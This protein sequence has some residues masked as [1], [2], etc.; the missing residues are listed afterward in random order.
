ME[1]W[2]WR[3]VEESL[4]EIEGPHYCREDRGSSS[5][6]A[7]G[8]R[9]PDTGG[10]SLL[11]SGK[12]YSQRSPSPHPQ[13]LLHSLEGTDEDTP[14]RR[15]ASGRRIHPSLLGVFNYGLRLR[16]SPFIDSLL[17]TIG[18]PLGE[19]G[20]FSWVTLT[21]FQVGYLSVGVAPNLNLFS[22]IFNVIHQGV[23]SYFYTGSGV[24]NML[25]TEKPGK[26]NPTRWHRYWF[27]VKDAFSDDVPHHFSMDYT[28][29]N[30][31]DFEETTIEFQKLVDG[32][33]RALPLIK[34]S[35]CK[36]ANNF[37]NMTL[38]NDPP[39][40][41]H[42]GASEAAYAMFL[43]W[44]EAEK[45]KEEFERQKSSFGESLRMMREE[46][47]LAL[48]EK[49]K[50]AQT[51]YFELLK[52]N[53]ATLVH[54]FCHDVSIDFPDTSSHFKMYVTD[55]GEDYVTSPMMRKLA[56]TSRKMMMKM[57]MVTP[58]RVMKIEL[59]MGLLASNFCVDTSP[60][61]L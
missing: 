13:P 19:L 32:F 60:F 43:Q 46:R 44:S 50:V 7:G 30:P 6:Q 37:P 5:K 4:Q 40:V 23:L 10:I 52:G 25:D 22:K 1:K 28:A 36:G 35:L 8:K 2:K 11:N 9:I 12:H 27:L 3:G 24:K 26:A 41:V 18:R 39:Q 48:V 17:S 15:D 49:E 56:W 55:L 38:C 57:L 29:L 20:P 61:V 58:P 16:A 45:D 42:P 21:A 33:A 51:E 53:T 59:T 54:G 34:A 31:E 47:D 14:R